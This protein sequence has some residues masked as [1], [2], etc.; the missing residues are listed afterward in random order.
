MTLRDRAVVGFLSLVLVV[1]A[2]VV[3]A[4]S[5]VPSRPEA[6]PRPSLPSLRP[7]VEGVVG[8]ATSVSP[9][10]ARTAVERA[11]VALLFRGL[12]RL[13]PD[14]TL[15]GDLA[16]RWEVDPNGGTWTFH[17]RDGLVWQD[18]QALTADDVL[19]TIAA[20]SAPD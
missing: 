11:M 2:A 15:V 16:E 3:V 17:L 18:G 20:L 5:L 9:F 12:V 6:S 4:P 8:S 13:G 19:F 10:S 1:L 7:Y 14:D